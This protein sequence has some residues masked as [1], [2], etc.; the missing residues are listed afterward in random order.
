MKFFRIILKVVCV[1]IAVALTLTAI[2]FRNNGVNIVS[3]DGKNDVRA[4]SVSVSEISA[5]KYKKIAE[6]GYLE[7]YFNEN[8]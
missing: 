5:K 2:F 3:L 4:E 7:L 1:L 8:C 6:S